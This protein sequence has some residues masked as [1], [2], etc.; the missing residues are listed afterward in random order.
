MRRIFGRVA[1]LTNYLQVQDYFFDGD[2]L[3]FLIGRQAFSTYEECLFL[4]FPASGPCNSSSIEDDAFIQQEW[5][6]AVAVALAQHS[7]RVVNYD[8]IANRYRPFGDPV[9]TREI[10]H[11]LG[12]HA[13]Q[14]T[15]FFD[16]AEEANQGSSEH[17]L[18]VF[19]SHTDFCCPGIDKIDSP[20]LNRIRNAACG[21]IWEKGL[22]Y[23][24]L[25][26]S[27][28]GSKFFLAN[29]S[30]GLP[31]GYDSDRLATIFARSLSR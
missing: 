4:G 8:F 5:N 16:N 19:V 18:S 12:L 3:D 27:Y 15:L 28:N 7:E 2:S 26:L 14:K 6:A 23:L 13:K 30:A 1:C 20:E 29:V 9:K 21:Y 31:I 17:L 25:D 11:G 24:I 22:N 10:A